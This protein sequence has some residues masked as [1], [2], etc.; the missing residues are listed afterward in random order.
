MEPVKVVNNFISKQECSILIKEINKIVK[1][2]IDNFSIYQDGKRLALQFGN[3]LYHE[4]N[5]HLDLNIISESEPLFRKYF[6]SVVDQTAKLF[7][8]NK[9]MYVSSFWIAKQFPGAEVPEHED[10]DGGKNTHFD[11]SA[12]LYLNTL[13]DSGDLEFPYLKYSYSPKAGDLVVFPSRTTGTH[14]V[15]KINEDRYTLPM[16][17]TKNKD[18]VL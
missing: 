8:E 6:S 14:V 11:Y 3:D 7:D 12:V 18:F 1:E 2:Q 4:H 9:K 5:S 15:N 10:T 16:W 13:T 17:I